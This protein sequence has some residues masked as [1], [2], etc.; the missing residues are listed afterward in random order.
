[1][2]THLRG[3]IFSLDGISYLV[4]NTDD[5]SPEWVRV[6]SLGPRREVRRMRVR[7]VERAV[8]LPH[9]EVG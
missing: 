2:H 5:E 4:L 6:S 1:M 3:R 7:E 9:R 8:P